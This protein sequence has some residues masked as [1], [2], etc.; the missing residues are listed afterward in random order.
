MYSLYTDLRY[1]FRLFVKAPGFTV[2]ALLTLALGVGANT[3]IFTIVNGVLL[4]PMPYPEPDRLVRVWP[5]KV[6]NEQMLA[7]VEEQTESF[8]GLTGYLGFRFTLTDDAEA[9]AVEGA[10][11]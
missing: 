9:R 3:T 10:G 5:E 4:E 1:A 8:A 7:E 11:T 6:L 2:V